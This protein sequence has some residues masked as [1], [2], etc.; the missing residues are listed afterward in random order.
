MPAATAPP[1]AA[2][3]LDNG[4]MS[5]ASEHQG[6]PRLVR[7][8]VPSAPVRILPRS[9]SPV[10]LEAVGLVCVDGVWRT[11][12]DVLR[13]T[14]TRAL[15]V[16][17]SGR[18]VAEYADPPG[19]LETPRLLMSITKSVVGCVAGVL[20]AR[21]VLS[22]HDR[23]I[24]LVPELARGYGSATVRDLLDM[25]TGVDYD[26]HAD[27]SSRARV[28][29]EV[30]YLP[31][32]S[33]ASPESAR[34][35]LPALAAI[36]PPGGAFTYRSADTDALGWVLERATDRPLVDLVADIV[37]AG[38]GLEGDA[39]M[40]TDQWGD[41]IASGGLMLAPRD[42]ARFGLMLA[43]GGAVGP[44]QVVP[45]A[46]LQDTLR[47]APDSVAAMTAAL[48][49]RVSPHEAAG[50]RGFY[51]NQFWVPD[52]TGER[53]LCLGIHGQALLVDTA[54]DLV[55]VKLSWWPTPQDPARFTDGIAALDHLADHLDVRPPP[56]GP[57]TR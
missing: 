47:G 39:W 20:I 54:R 9:P 14:D 40:V 12:T 17:R 43:S 28:L 7:L 57:F 29:G 50:S 31:A 34:A 42:L 51:R 6:G 18:I 26:E 2:M 35:Y 45:V 44:R 41:A 55:A 3:D 36:R 25:R 27:V 11:V 13:R 23:V 15:L 16:V 19:T 30:M 22:A 56:T 10:D 53:L 32:T 52:R 24:D 38:L 33:W 8:P 37:L 5:R 49:S 21:G 1:R 4:R 46:F 48:A